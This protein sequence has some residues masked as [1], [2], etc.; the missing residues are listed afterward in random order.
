MDTNSKK[1]YTKKKSWF[2]ILYETKAM[3]R[4]NEHIVVGEKELEGKDMKKIRI[5]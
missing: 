5:R 1:P 3:R 2:E 4:L